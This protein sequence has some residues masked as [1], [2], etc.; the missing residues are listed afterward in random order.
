MNYI[1]QIHLEHKDDVIR[2]I[3]I[4]SSKSLEDLHFT[5]IKCLKLDKYEMASFYTTNDNFDL[6]QEIPIFKIDSN[7]SKMQYM[8]Q[9]KMNDGEYM[10]F[11]QL[12][13]E[14]YI[15]F[16]LFFMIFIKFL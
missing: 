4:P 14:R 11:V 9:I 2:D 1:I 8:S 7:N 13:K 5:I 6:L 3:K 10:I 16:W 15:K 12:V